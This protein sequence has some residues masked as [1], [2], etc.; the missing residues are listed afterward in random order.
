MMINNTLYIGKINEAVE[1]GVS[2]FLSLDLEVKQR[3]IKAAFLKQDR[4]ERMDLIK[5]ATQQDSI[6]LLIE[7]LIRTNGNDSID[8]SALI[9]EEC[10]H[11]IKS[12]LAEQANLDIQKKY[13]ETI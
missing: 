5:K 13:K 12:E 2:D 10:L 11:F 9:I 6:V 4:S 7:S 8:T 3:L 1:S